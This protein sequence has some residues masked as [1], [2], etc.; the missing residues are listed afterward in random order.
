MLL[1]GVIG[2]QRLETR[3]GEIDAER[4]ESWR[5]NVN[6]LVGR[7]PALRR[8]AMDD[9]NHVLHGSLRLLF[10]G[11]GR[12]QAGDE[13]QVYWLANP[14]SNPEFTW[15]LHRL[16]HWQVLLRGHLLDD[17]GG[18]GRRVI[19]EMGDWLAVCSPPRIDVQRAEELFNGKRRESFLGEWA[20]QYMRGRWL[21]Y[22]QNVRYFLRRR[23]K[24]ERSITV[25]PH[26]VWR[27]ME[28]GWRMFDAWPLLQ[29]FLPALHYEW[30]EELA[31]SP[32]AAGVCL[33]G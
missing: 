15:T 23:Q 13:R 22:T 32:G 33:P 10:A 12:V 28:V 26:H 7:E 6:L 4:I 17:Q 5:E 25:A 20:A 21:R 18:Y 29:E 3:R 8:D 31:H 1:D 9:A 19:A 27:A 24:K 30:H 14:T 11:M 16:E 2:E